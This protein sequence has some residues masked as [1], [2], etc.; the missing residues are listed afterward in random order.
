M[1]AL[2]R[3]AIWCML[4]H[5]QQSARLSGCF[6]PAIYVISS[7]CDSTGALENDLLSWKYLLGFT[8]EG[9]R[10]V[11]HKILSL[12]KYV[13]EKYVWGGRKIWDTLCTCG[14]LIYTHTL[15]IR[16]LTSDQD[17]FSLLISS[18]CRHWTLRNPEECTTMHLMNDVCTWFT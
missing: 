9:W 2:E 17:A 13:K 10:S 1:I 5:L 12:L 18:T 8:A 14:Y 16:C 15:L 11:V 4:K 3:A 6:L 7:A